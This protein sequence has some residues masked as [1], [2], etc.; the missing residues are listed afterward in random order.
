MTVIYSFFQ[1]DFTEP[2]LLKSGDI[3]TS[4]FI[5]YLLGHIFIPTWQVRKLRL[6]RFSNYLIS[7]LFP[8][9]SPNP[10]PPRQSRLHIGAFEI[11]VWSCFPSAEIWPGFPI[12]LPQKTKVCTKAY[13]AQYSLQLPP[14]SLRPHLLLLSLQP[15]SPLAPSAHGP[16]PRPASRPGCSLKSTLPTSSPLQV[17]AQMLPFQRRPILTLT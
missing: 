12:L 13:G 11:F 3:F 15:S 10:L 9:L 17:F 2:H 16:W 5:E 14:F 6:I 4:H 7:L 1:Q 8:W